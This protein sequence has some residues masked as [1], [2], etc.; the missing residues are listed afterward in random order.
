MRGTMFTAHLKQFLNLKYPEFP[1]LFT[2]NENMV[3]RYSDGYKEAKGSLKIIKK[4]VK[5]EDI[6]DE[7]QIYKLFVF[8]KET[9]RY[10]V[11]ERRP[12]ESLTENFGY[13]YI[14]D[15]IDSYNEGDTITKD[16]ILYKSTSYDEDMNYGYGINA[17][18]AYTFD[19]FT[20]E[21]AAIAS[22]S[23]CEDMTSIETDEIEILLNSNDYFV[24][25]YGD[26]KQYKPI[27]DIGEIVSDRIC[28]VRRLFNNQVLYDFK[29]S[30]LME[31]HEGDLIFF[32]DKN[33]KVIDIDIYNNNDEIVD[34]PFN[35]QI[36]KYLR[37]QNKYY[38]KIYKTC[39]E[40]I[41]SGKDYSQD[42]D[43]L[44]KRSQEYLDTKKKWRS[45]DSEFNNLKIVISV[46]RD[47]PLSIGCKLTGK[48]ICS[49]KTSLI[50]GN[51]LEL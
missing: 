2:S 31:I 17:L 3:G 4:I 22:E 1:H 50:A 11:I 10:E 21:D 14:N 28:A 16:S 24:N 38:R 48:H 44:Y 19:P 5:Y 49:C 7:P 45:S 18:V 26:N 20:S 13:E 8:N 6:L 37:S 40:I 42:I 15:A 23:F 33:V 35:A 41:E 47:V 27:P 46:K 34:T 29:E 25:M 12:C 51:T 36:N 9:N 39:K 32:V 30:S 43:Y